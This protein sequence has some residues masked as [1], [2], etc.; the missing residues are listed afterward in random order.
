MK[1]VNAAKLEGFKTKHP[2]ARKA[3]GNWEAV[4]E[5]VTCRNFVEL[6]A[7]FTKADC[8]K[9]HTIFNVGGNKYRLTTLVN[10]PQSLILIEFALTHDEYDKG[11]WK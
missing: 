4:V 5:A 3:I 7:A 8:A 1:I 9:P 11:G 2:A 10:Y 6:K